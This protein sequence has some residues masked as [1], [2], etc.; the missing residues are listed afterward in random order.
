M[1]S[2]KMQ[3]FVRVLILKMTKHADIIF[4]HCSKQY[5]YLRIFY[6][7]SNKKTT[8]TADRK[9][10]RL[11]SKKSDVCWTGQWHFNN[12]YDKPVL[13]NRIELFEKYHDIRYDSAKNTRS[14][15]WYRKSCEIIKN[16]WNQMRLGLQ[17]KLKLIQILLMCQ[18]RR[19][20]LQKVDSRW[21]ST[22]G[23]ARLWT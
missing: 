7:G 15:S 22:Q 14:G 6:K 12:V 1:R 9:S 19:K 3:K 18:T 8:P 5:R 11:G 16:I 10:R 2:C 20:I 13:E 4:K 21:Q 23:N 17:N